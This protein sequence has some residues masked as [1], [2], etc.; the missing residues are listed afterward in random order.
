M[1]SSEVGKNNFRIKEAWIRDQGMVSFSG[2]MVAS[3]RKIRYQW[4]GY[5]SNG[6]IISKG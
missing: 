4:M 1:K 2:N 6:W 3:S 5:F